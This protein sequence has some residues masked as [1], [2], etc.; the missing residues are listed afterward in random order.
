[1][2][3]SPVPKPQIPARERGRN[4]LVDVAGAEEGRTVSLRGDYE[5]HMGVWGVDQLGPLRTILADVYAQVRPARVAVLGCGTGNGLDVVDPALTRRVIGLDL[6]PEYLALA[7][8]RY[9]DLAG[10]AEWMC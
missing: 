3:R 10:I 4:E 7:Q 6:N 1:M 2:H 8:E 9:P 5:G